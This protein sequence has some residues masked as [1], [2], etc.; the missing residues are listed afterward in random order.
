MKPEFK[1]A[2]HNLIWQKI[3]N[4]EKILNNH[5]VSRLNRLDKRFWWII[6]LIITGILLNKLF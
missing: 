4:V 5:I 6:G 2:E 3:E 1:D